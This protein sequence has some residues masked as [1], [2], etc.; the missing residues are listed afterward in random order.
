MIGQTI[1]TLPS[2]STGVIEYPTLKQLPRKELELSFALQDAED[3]ARRR[4]R[5]RFSGVEAFKWTSLTSCN[6][7]MIKSAYD[8]LIDVGQSDWLR[9]CSE[10]SARVGSGP[11]A[12]HHY[13]IFFDDG[14]CFEVIAESASG[15]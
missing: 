5:L 8:K 11:K 6:E 1:W 7:E 3:D 13:R 15:F 9:Q 2:P 4:F 10:I 14:P 12:L